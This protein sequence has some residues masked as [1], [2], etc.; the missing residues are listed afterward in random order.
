MSELIEVPFEETKSAILSIDLSNTEDLS[1]DKLKDFLDTWGLIMP[2]LSHFNALPL[3]LSKD[4]QIKDLEEL[5]E[6][7]TKCIY[8]SDGGESFKLFQEKTQSYQQKYPKQ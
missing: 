6:S 4:Q 2:K 7:A 5:L 3:L 1:N 8:T